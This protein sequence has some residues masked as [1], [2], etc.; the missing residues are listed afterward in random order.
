VWYAWLRPT[1][2]EPH[3][4]N[5]YVS[6][7]YVTTRQ[8]LRLGIL[9]F[10]C[11]PLL[12]ISL[13]FRDVFFCCV[14]PTVRH[15]LD[16]A[17]TRCDMLASRDTIAFQEQS[18]DHPGGSPRRL[19]A[20]WWPNTA[21]HKSHAQRVSMPCFNFANK[22]LMVATDGTMIH[23]Y[24]VQDGDTARRHIVQLCVR[25]TA[26]DSTIDP[27]H[28]PRTIPATL[29]LIPS[30]IQLQTGRRTTSSLQTILA[31]PNTSL[32]FA[33]TASTHMYT[34]VSLVLQKLLH[35]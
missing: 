31:Y 21:K 13:F 11:A 4:G 6:P 20:S 7:T 9:E 17:R 3:A 14:F 12:V 2:T 25:P 16:M 8:F 32:R 34:R 28:K 18:H 27:H 30:T 15:Y 22:K 19:M 35:F 5:L 26:A 1:L 29:L 33:P 23:I 24:G 10:R